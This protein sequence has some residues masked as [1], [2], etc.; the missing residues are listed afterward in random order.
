M[1][2]SSTSLWMK[3]FSFPRRFR[4]LD[5]LRAR[6]VFIDYGTLITSSPRP[7]SRLHLSYRWSS[8]SNMNY[9]ESHPVNTLYSWTRRRLPM[10]SKY[11]FTWCRHPHLMSK[12]SIKS[13]RVP[14][15]D[16]TSCLIKKNRRVLLP[17]LLLLLT[18]LSGIFPPTLYYY[19]WCYHQ[20]LHEKE[21][22]KKKKKKKGGPC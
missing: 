13:M 20:S 5:L 3:S 21:K 11:T 10:R 19:L 9:V 12:S 15:H 1:L 7:P 22:K 8:S 4:F 16:S 2:S 6:P 17:L 18:P 14:F